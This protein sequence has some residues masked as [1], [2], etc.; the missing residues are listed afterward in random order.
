MDRRH[1]SRPLD[2]AD[3]ATRMAGEAIQ[4][5]GGNG[6]INDYPAGRPWRDA[7]LDEIGAGTGAIRRILIGG[8]LFSETTW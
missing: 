5:L 3:K 7:R 1:S 4:V 8:E 6:C 2:S